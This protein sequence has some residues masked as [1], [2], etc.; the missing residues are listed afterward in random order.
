MRQGRIIVIGHQKGNKTDPRSLAQ[1]GEWC[2]QNGRETLGQRILDGDL[3]SY[4]MTTRPEKGD[5]VAAIKRY[6]TDAV[7]ALHLFGIDF[8]GKPTNSKFLRNRKRGQF[9][10]W[11]NWELLDIC[12]ERGITLLSWGDQPRLSGHQ[13]DIRRT[14]ILGSSYIYEAK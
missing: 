13:S 12:A 5:A 7:I 2:L 8:D 9:Y 14:Q 11:R 4:D 1:M 3:D 10:N 6:K